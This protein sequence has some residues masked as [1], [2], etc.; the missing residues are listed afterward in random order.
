[1]VGGNTCAEATKEPTQAEHDAAASSALTGRDALFFANLGAD[2]ISGKIKALKDQRK[3]MLEEK[4]A[5]AR[6]LR[7]A[8]RQRMRLKRKAKNLNAD[9]LVEVLT[10]RAAAQKKAKDEASA[11]SAEETSSAQTLE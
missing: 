11:A 2:M 5:V 3:Q 10:I 6:A 8:Q 1:M 7:N 4:K 9:D